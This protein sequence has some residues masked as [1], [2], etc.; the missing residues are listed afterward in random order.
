MFYFNCSLP[1]GEIL[2]QEI[3]WN[4]PL[5]H[6]VRELTS[7]GSGWYSKHSHIPDVKTTCSQHESPWVYGK[8]AVAGGGYCEFIC[9]VQTHP[10]SPLCH[11]Y[12]HKKNE[13]FLLCESLGMVGCVCVFYERWVSYMECGGHMRWAV[14]VP[15]WYQRGFLTDGCCLSIKR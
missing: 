8:R 13:E 15:G 4:V 7:C 11:F 1:I 5:I 9:T 14:P 10:I 2:Q 12:I 3:L 6:V